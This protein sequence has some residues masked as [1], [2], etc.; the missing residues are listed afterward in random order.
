[1]SV[2]RTTLGDF[3]PA[4]LAMWWY[5]IIYCTSVPHLDSVNESLLVKRETH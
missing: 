4:I 1:M 5:W 2:R 3:A